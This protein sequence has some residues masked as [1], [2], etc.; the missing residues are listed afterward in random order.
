MDRADK[1]LNRAFYDT[2]R[3]DDRV[4]FEEHPS[5][6]FMTET[7]VPWVASLVGPDARIV[8]I[9]GGSGVYASGIVRAA[10]VSVVGLDISESMIRQRSEDPLLPEN[11]VGDME[12]LP[13]A[14]GEFDAALFVNCLHHVPDPL[15]ALREAHRVV[16]AGGALFAAEPCSLRVGPAGIAPV[17][18]YPHEFRFSMSYLRGRI[19]TAGFAIDSIQGKRMT[20]RFARPVLRSPRIGAFR[21]AD[22]VDRALTLIPG[23]TRFAELAL[24]HAHRV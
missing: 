6:V 23:V 10:P 21:A 2:E 24:V 1:D 12:A 22:R 3:D 15:P 7:L 11:V 5:K 19:H 8:D 13:F 18:G 20:L 9:A 16:R 17:P 14:D 4:R